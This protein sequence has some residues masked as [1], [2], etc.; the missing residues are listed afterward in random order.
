MVNEIGDRQLQQAR[1][2]DQAAIT[3]IYDT[4]HPKIYRYIYRRVG[5]VEVGRD[6]T[7]EVFRR[8]LQAVQ[9][10]TGP[11]N[12]LQAWLYRTAHNIVIDHYR[13]QQHRNHLHLNES[14]PGADSE[15]EWVVD[16]SLLNQTLRQAIHALTP[17]QQ[18]VITLKF[19][20]GFSNGEVAE[21]VKKPI[22][23]VKS[24]QHR[25]LNALQRHLAP[26]RETA[27]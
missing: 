6:L 3:A 5:D 24:L 4:F 7:A 13:R 17:E 1:A 10:G 12:Q 23:A 20:E 25:A 19:L 26:S 18:Q 14:I 21:I 27:A 22:G 2:F 15:L 8:F 11:E 16:Q 9:N